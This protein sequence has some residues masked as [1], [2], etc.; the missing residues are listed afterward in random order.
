MNVRYGSAIDEQAAD[1]QAKG[2]RGLRQTP[3]IRLERENTSK[4]GRM[5]LL[6]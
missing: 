2:E 5:K 6:R 4:C 1:E 3:L